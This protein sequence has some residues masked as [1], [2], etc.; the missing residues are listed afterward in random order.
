MDA[1]PPVPTPP[2][3]LWREFRIQWMPVLVFLG[4][5]AAA[6]ALWKTSLG[7]PMLVGQVEAVQAAVRSPDVGILVA[8][9]VTNYQQ[10]AKDD[11]VAELDTSDPRTSAARANLLDTRV[12]LLGEAIRHPELDQ[13][14]N[15]LDYQRL[16]LELRNH[17]LALATAEVNLQRA[18][19]EFERVKG[20]FEAKIVSERAYEIAQRAKEALEVEIRERTELVSYLTNRLP[21]FW[22]RIERSRSLATQQLAQVEINRLQVA[23]LATNNLVLRAPTNGV[24]CNVWHRPGE[25]VRA[26]DVILTVQVPRSE[27]IV[28][29]LRQ[30]L[31]VEPEVGM[32]VQVRTRSMVK[33]VGW[34]KIL[35]VGPQMEPI[36]AALLRPG[37]NIEIGLPIAIS[38]PPELNL[39]PGELVDLAILPKTEAASPPLDSRL[40]RIANPPTPRTVGSAQ[41]PP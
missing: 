6:V 9:T 10:V 26:G 41:G 22:A 29:Y 17:R 4:A 15:D 20:L 39:R 25:V 2:T 11:P 35:N 7:A 36:S 37:M 33:R 28:C 21:E 38:V 30:P 24:V 1:L 13:Q 27:R 19:E 31:P 34:G 40:V 23:G 16:Q 3:K 14:R 8:L 32:Q 5:V 18:E 12:R